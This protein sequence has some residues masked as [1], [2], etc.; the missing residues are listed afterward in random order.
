MSVVCTRSTMKQICVLFLFIQPV[1]PK[2]NFIGMGLG[3][4]RVHRR[5]VFLSLLVFTPC[6]KSATVPKQYNKDLNLRTAVPFVHWTVKVQHMHRVNPRATKLFTVSVTSERKEDH[7][8]PLPPTPPAHK[9]SKW[10][11]IKDQALAC[12]Q[13]W[14]S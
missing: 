13:L 7:L 14:V 12:K 9:L 1:S 6:Y 5:L 8:D 2:L 3:P 11:H 10:L 4:K